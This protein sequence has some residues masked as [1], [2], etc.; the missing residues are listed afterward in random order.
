MEVLSEILIESGVSLSFSGSS[1]FIPVLSLTRPFDFPIPEKRTANLAN[2]VNL[3]EVDGV[4][5]NRLTI[6]EQRVNP[7]APAPFVISIWT[8]SSACSGSKI[9]IARDGYLLP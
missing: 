6:G 2:R 1:R 9:T 8:R 3:F 7:G 4:R 5:V